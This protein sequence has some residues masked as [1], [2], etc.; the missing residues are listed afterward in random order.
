LVEAVGWDMPVV[1]SLGYI[2]KAITIRR[3]DC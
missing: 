2:L 1:V 3:I